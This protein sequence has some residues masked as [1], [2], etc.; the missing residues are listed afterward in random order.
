VENFK[1]GYVFTAKDFVIPEGVRVAE[2][3]VSYLA[4]LPKTLRTDAVSSK[5]FS[6]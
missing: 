4:T 1:Q 5:I 2:K 3:I 6:V